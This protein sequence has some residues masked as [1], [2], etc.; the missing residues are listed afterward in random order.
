MLKKKNTIVLIGILLAALIILAAAAVIPAYFM[1]ETPRAQARQPEEEHTMKAVYLEKED[2]NSIFVDLTGQYPFTGTFP[3]GQLYDENG[4]KITEE[5]FNS[6]DVLNIWGNGV[7]A[8]SYPAQYNGITKIERTEQANQNYIEEYGHYLEELFVEKDPSLRPALNVCYTDDLAHTAVMVPEALG[9]NWTYED[10]EGESQ[11]ITADAPHILLTES[12]E[13]T[14]LS[15]PLQMEL[16]FDVKPENV[17]LLSWEAPQPGQYQD[18]TAALPEGTAVEVTIN[19]QGNPVFTAHPGTIYQ[20]KG[21]WEN[22]TVDYS[23][24]VSAK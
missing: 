17:Q 4:K 18:G 9:Y 10:Q 15:E 16:E 23:F 21:Q 11:T 24:H 7:I 6:G 1:N 3:Q 5:D 8:Q 19:E 12:T 22:G 20:V 2:G 13:I 14:K